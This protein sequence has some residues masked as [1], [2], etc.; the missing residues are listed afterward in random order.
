MVI[1]TFPKEEFDVVWAFEIPNPFKIQFVRTRR[2]NEVVARFGCEEATRG[3]T[4]SHSILFSEI[5]W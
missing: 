1:H 5:I 4:L 3:N 2:I